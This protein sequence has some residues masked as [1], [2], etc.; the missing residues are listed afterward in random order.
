MTTGVAGVSSPALFS[1][2]A[3]FV[4]LGM[5]FGGMP[6]PFGIPF[7]LAFRNC[8]RNGFSNLAQSKRRPVLQ[9]QVDGCAVIFLQEEVNRRADRG[10][11]EQSAEEVEQ[12]EAEAEKTE[13][14]ALN[15]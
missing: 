7:L 3:A 12:C 13:H 10:D 6:S 4:E 8:G 1:S 15:R 14:H 11:Q 5:A 2:S 9:S